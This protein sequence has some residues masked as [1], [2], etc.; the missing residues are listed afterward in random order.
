MKVIIGSDHAG[1][2]LKEKI[3]EYFRKNN[4]ECEDVGPF[5][6]DKTDDYPDFVIR[7]AKK[8]AR[9]KC[10]GIIIGYSGQ[11][12][13]ITANKFKGIRAVVYYGGNKKIIKLTREHNDANILSLGAGFLNEKNAI[14]SL[15]LWL[16]TNFSNEKRH[17][18]RL[19]KISDFERK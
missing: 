6:Y 16:K 13:A 14:E 19:R 15:K 2:R 10:M 5:N 9:L 8:V 1:F 7:V 18:R 11:G 17:K 12:E 4:V 3:K